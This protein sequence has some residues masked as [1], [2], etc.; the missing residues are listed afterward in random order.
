MKFAYVREPV[1]RKTGQ[2][3]EKDVCARPYFAAMLVGKNARIQLT[4]SSEWPKE[5]NDPVAASEPL[6]SALKCGFDVRSSP[7]RTSLRASSWSSPKENSYGLVSIPDY[8]WTTDFH[9]SAVAASVGFM[10]RTCNV[11]LHSLTR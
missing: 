7:T 11:C 5:L 1:K 6:M 8:R 9:L 3:Q 2:M 4:F 10:I